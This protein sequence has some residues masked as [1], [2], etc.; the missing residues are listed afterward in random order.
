MEKKETRKISLH[1]ASLGFS[2]KN[3]DS[4]TTPT[5]PMFWAEQICFITKKADI[6]WRKVVREPPACCDFIAQ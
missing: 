3:A 2:L 1:I 6:L 5:I 4:M